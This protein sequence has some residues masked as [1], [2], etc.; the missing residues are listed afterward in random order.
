[1][2]FTA[3]FSL[4]FKVAVTHYLCTNDLPNTCYF[5]AT[6]GAIAAE[7]AHV[8]IIA[9]AAYDASAAMMAEGI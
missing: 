5:C 6:F 9:A 7:T 1:M 3:V 4:L 8:Y 2:S